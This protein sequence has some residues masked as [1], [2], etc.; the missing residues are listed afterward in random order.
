MLCLRAD[1]LAVEKML[2]WLKYY[3]IC[4]TYTNL[5]VLNVFV[6]I[7]FLYGTLG[8][9]LVLRFFP[10]LEILD[11]VKGFVIL[12]MVC[13]HAGAWV[14]RHLLR[15]RIWLLA[16]LF[17]GFVLRVSDVVMCVCLYRDISVN[18]ELVGWLSNA[19]LI[20]IELRC[21]TR[22]ARLNGVSFA[23][24][25]IHVVAEFDLCIVLRVAHVVWFA[26]KLWTLPKIGC[27]FPYDLI[28]LYLGERAIL[29]VCVRLVVGSIC[30]VVKSVLI[31]SGCFSFGFVLFCG[32]E[33]A[34]G[35]VLVFDSMEGV[36][37]V[38][39]YFN[40]F[41]VIFIVVLVLHVNFDFDFD[42]ISVVVCIVIVWVARDVCVVLQLLSGLCVVVFWMVADLGYLV[43]VCWFGDVAGVCFECDFDTLLVII[44]LIRVLLF[45]WRG[46]L[47][48][49]FVSLCVCNVLVNICVGGLLGCMFLWMRKLGLWVWSII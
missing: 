4:W 30:L 21:V 29:F 8:W 16:D 6:D 27:G 45:E 43:D 41:F 5:L 15:T 1:S 38:F 31:A 17:C 42:L 3:T 47:A 32:P 20:Y 2:Q 37:W 9:S 28:R 40:S 34:D 24:I 23:I 14:I 39:Q 44:C 19:A 33:N 12:C 36:R 18:F 11:L 13:I 49:L 26:A 25:D 46:F 48:V 22:V 10:Y 7:W 35:F